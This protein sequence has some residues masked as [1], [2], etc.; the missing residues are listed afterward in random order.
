[1][2]GT[3]YSFIWHQFWTTR[4]RHPENTSKKM[5][6]GGT[7][8]IKEQKTGKRK[9]LKMTKTLKKKSESTSKICHYIT[10]YFKV[11][12]GKTNHLTDGQL[13]GY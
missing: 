10:I 5:C 1:M 8:K 4:R 11:A 6:K 3:T 12:S 2:S 9:Q 7:S 13:I